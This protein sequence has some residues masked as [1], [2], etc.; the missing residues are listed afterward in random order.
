MRLI[1]CPRLV[2]SKKSLFRVMG[3]FVEFEFPEEITR[4]CEE[5]AG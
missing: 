1:I 4:L 5:L 2:E 3:Q